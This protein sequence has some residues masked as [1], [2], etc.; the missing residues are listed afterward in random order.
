M[1]QGRCG[2]ANTALNPH[3]EELPVEN[4]VTCGPS[5]YKHCAAAMRPLLPVLQLQPSDAAGLAHLSAASVRACYSKWHKETHV[6]WVPHLG[7]G[8]TDNGGFLLGTA[9]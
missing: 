6:V 2:N 8:S 3:A 7:I 9:M 5:P 4:Q 1:V